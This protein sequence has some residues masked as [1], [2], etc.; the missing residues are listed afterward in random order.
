M[1][2]TPDR[3]PDVNSGLAD[4]D[5]AE[6]TG[7]AEPLKKTPVA[8]AAAKAEQ[9]VVGAAVKAEQAVVDVAVKAE[10][11]VVDAA[12]NAAPPAV[13]EVAVDAE[14]AVEEVVDKAAARRWSVGDSIRV[15]IALLTLL[16]TGLA[17]SLGVST[18]E[19]RTFEFVNS[20]PDA[21]YPVIWPVM[22]LGN[23]WVA[24]TLAFGLGLIVRKPK[25]SVILAAAPF[26]AWIV[27][28]IV[29]EI[30]HRGRPQALGMLVQPNRG[31]GE[32]GFGFISGHATV[33]FALAGALI[34]HLRKPW[35]YVVFAMAT[36][37]G[38]ARI[39]V[40]AHLPLDVIGGAATGLLIGEAARL[41]ETRRPSKAWRRR[42]AQAQAQQRERDR[43]REMAS[44]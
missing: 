39:Y 35:N 15:T 8:D 6:P 29:K 34:P 43:D 30:V 4:V 32:S 37:V 42:K 18:Q 13:V 24:V 11:A 19:A 36:V 3:K 38:L 12:V 5:G 21:L 27:A 16:V 44:S 25:A 33:A 22:Q 14:H 17:A 9:A 31:P 2:T 40:G 23:V 1:G 7:E 28:K 20:A 10:Q 26:T 41:I